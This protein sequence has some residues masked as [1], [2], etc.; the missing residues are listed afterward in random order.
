MPRGELPRTIAFGDNQ[1]FNILDVGAFLDIERYAKVN[2]NAAAPQALYDG[3]AR[4]DAASNSGFLRRSVE[5][6]RQICFADQATGRIYIR[7]VGGK[8]VA[9]D[10][11]AL[12][13]ALA[14]TDTLEGLRAVM[15]DAFS[16]AVPALGAPMYLR[17]ALGE[18]ETPETIGQWGA[19]P[20]GAL[21]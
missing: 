2:V 19:A 20:A 6:F 8:P 16:G 4:L 1:T 13:R 11:D 18:A 15:P 9:V 12:A 3:R 10:R 7:V 14:D 21:P 17:N 5:A